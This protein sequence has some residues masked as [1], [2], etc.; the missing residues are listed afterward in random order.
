M[1]PWRH[2]LAAI[3]LC[4]PCAARA[5]PA[6]QSPD[7]DFDT[8][9]ARFAND[10]Q[11]QLDRTLYPLQVQ[12]GLAG[13][14]IKQKWE[15]ARLATLDAPLVARRAEL[16][17]QGLRQYARQLKAK[18]VELMQFRPGALDS[19]RFYLFKLKRGCWYLSSFTDRAPATQTARQ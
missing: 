2:G 3:L 5:A 17:S 13:A 18:Q 6:C 11:F 7:A 16:S 8:F 15:R 19:G 12:L 4:V 14:S 10:R 9:I 1:K